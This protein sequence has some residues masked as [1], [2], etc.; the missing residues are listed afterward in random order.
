MTHFDI[1]NVM[2]RTNVRQC[3]FNVE[4]RMI[5]HVST[6]NHELL[7]TMFNFNDEQCSFNVEQR[8]AMTHFNHVSIMEM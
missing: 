5:N 6:M 4:H 7:S 1:E 2:V 8:M 3:S